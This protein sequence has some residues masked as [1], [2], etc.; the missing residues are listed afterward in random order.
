MKTP[1]IWEFNDLFGL[2]PKWV[3]PLILIMLFGR[4]LLTL[5]FFVFS[6]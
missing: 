3:L 1:P 2:M 5:L 4:L 6:F